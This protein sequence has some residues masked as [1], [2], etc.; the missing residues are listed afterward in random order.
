MAGKVFKVDSHT[1]V[2][3]GGTTVSLASLAVG[4]MAEVK[5]AVSSDGTLVALLMRVQPSK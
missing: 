2:L 1:V 5:E 3:R 4:E